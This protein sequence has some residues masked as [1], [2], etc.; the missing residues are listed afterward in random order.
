MARQS[1]S[2]YRHGVCPTWYNHLNTIMADFSVT[3]TEAFPARDTLRFTYLHEMGY[4]TVPAMLAE[5]YNPRDT[6]DGHPT[7]EIA[8]VMPPA[9]LD[10]KT[11]LRHAVGEQLNYMRS[12]WQIVGIESWGTIDPLATKLAEALLQE[13]LPMYTSGQFY[14]DDRACIPAALAQIPPRVSLADAMIRRSTLTVG[15]V[16]VWPQGQE[17]VSRAI[18][19]T[20]HRYD[21]HDVVSKGNADERGAAFHHFRGTVLRQLLQNTSGH[22]Y[23]DLVR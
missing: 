21:T 22:E 9:L 15:K 12:M 3:P 7:F 19:H 5:A 17:S 16:R 2:Y 23:G 1:N 13:S 4:R 6:S 10:D 18:V 20:L 8:Y 14:T 11:A